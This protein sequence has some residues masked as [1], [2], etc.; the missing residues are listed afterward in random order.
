MF[1][2]RIKM[3]IYFILVDEKSCTTEVN[4]NRFNQKIVGAK[5]G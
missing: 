5:L 4:T 1:T 3:H 2:F